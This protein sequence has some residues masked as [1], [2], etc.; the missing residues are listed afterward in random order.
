MCYVRHR[1]TVFRGWASGKFQW[2]KA[3]E[4][5]KRVAETFQGRVIDTSDATCTVELTDTCA[6]LDSFLETVGRQ[7]ILETVRT[8]ALGIGRGERIL[9]L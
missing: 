5:F 2:D 3:R 8:G 6:K 7:R 4:E 9:K 1:S